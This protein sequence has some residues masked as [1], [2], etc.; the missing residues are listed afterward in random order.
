MEKT[1]SKNNNSI[2]SSRSRL[3]ENSQHYTLVLMITDVDIKKLSKVFATKDDL[4]AMEARQDAKFATKDD[5]KAMEA[6]QNAKFATKIDIKGVREE[7]NGV[8]IDIKGV[9]EELNGVKIDIKGVR[10][11]LKKYATREDLLRMQGDLLGE[12]SKMRRGILEDLEVFFHDQIMPQFENYERRMTRT[13]K[14]L[15]LPPFAD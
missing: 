2:P 14:C 12:M 9:R 5:L 8:K 6:R 3:T 10:E 1:R 11:E 7:L 4:K 13:E 15:K